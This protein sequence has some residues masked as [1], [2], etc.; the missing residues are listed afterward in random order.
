MFLL[1]FSLL[2]LD[3]FVSIG[4]T[5]DPGLFPIMTLISLY[6]TLP[7]QGIIN[8]LIG[9]GIENLSYI[10]VPGY[11]LLLAGLSYITLNFNAKTSKKNKETL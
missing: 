4:S 2:N 11:I 7:F 8:T 3:F 10:I 6:T 5:P 1:L 9:Y